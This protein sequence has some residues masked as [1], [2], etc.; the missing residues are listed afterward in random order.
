MKKNNKQVT[1]LLRTRRVRTRIRATADRPRLAVHRSLRGMYAQ[2]IRDEEGKTL[3][4]V[5]SKT[6]SLTGDAGDRVGKTAESYL[7]GKELAKNAK[8]VGIST[9]VFD[10]GSYRYHGRVKAF[11]DGAREGG[12]VF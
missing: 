5:H 6:A 11:A 7:L 4:A 9:V 3:V 10:R 8:A 2:I 12:L 1:R